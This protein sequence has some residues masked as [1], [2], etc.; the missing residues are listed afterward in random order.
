V[1]QRGLGYTAELSN[2]AVVHGE[3]AN[4]IGSGWT[5]VDGYRFIDAQRAVTGG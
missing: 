1:V 3:L 5:P 2:G 4:R